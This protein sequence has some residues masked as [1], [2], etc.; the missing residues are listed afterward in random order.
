MSGRALAQKVQH[1][2][3]KA[4]LPTVHGE[5]GRAVPQLPTT[6]RWVVLASVA[7]SSRWTGG[8]AGSP[9]LAGEHQ[10]FPGSP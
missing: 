9:V 2:I 1:A 10:V 7:T 8:D 3:L 5:L 4:A 6:S